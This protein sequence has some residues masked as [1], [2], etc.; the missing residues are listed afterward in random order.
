M[1]NELLNKKYVLNPIYKIILDERR[2]LIL[3]VLD[4]SLMPRIIHPI[5]GKF[6]S[7]F[8]GNDICDITISKICNQ[9]NIS[10]E[11]AIT[12]V[13]RFV[14]NPKDI[15]VRYDGF[16]FRFPPLILIENVNGINR[17][18]LNSDKILLTA[19]YDFENIRLYKPLDIL[20]VINTKC[21]TDCVYCYADKRTQYTP[22]S[23]EKILDVIEQAKDLGVRKF[24]LTGGE[25][26]LHKDWK[27]IVKKLVDC[28]YGDLISTKIPL[29]KQQVDDFVE[30][31]MKT[32]QVSLD[33]LNPKLQLSNLNVDN[34]Y[35]ERMKESLRYIDSQNINIIIKGTLTKYTLTIE[36]IK[37]V[38]DFI[39]TLKHLKKYT[40]STIGASMYKT[41]D[42]FHDIKPSCDSIKYIY[43]YVNNMVKK[44]NIQQDSQE[45]LRKELCNYSK[46]K[47][48]SLCTG[49]VSGLIIL[50]DGKVTICEE[51]YWDN[52][53]IIGDLMKEK[54]LDVWN[55]EKALSLWNI[56]QDMFPK[57]SA[58]SSCQD[59]IKCR[60]GLGV[61]WKYVISVYGQHNYLYPDPRCPKA[62]SVI[63][64]VFYD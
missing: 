19:P 56:A 17:D 58:C 57:E 52:N 27:I 55:S 9:F 12:L 35:C 49:N 44:I 47:E 8:S 51:L 46:F 41:N 3:N 7:F 32:L 31:G 20:F 30:I 43:G 18:D 4:D 37:E 45:T 23:T 21:M 16:I 26:F 40:I 13:E 54:L 11:K 10:Y 2:L 34:L 53:F 64:D 63:N 36:N 61:C 29:T 42:S 15:F 5:F 62:P 14:E 25:V 24:E 59:F 1:K 6:L 48:R 60:R 28:G 38:T 39:S 33:S 50:P 22:M